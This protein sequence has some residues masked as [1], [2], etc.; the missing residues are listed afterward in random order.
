MKGIHLLAL[1]GPAY[2]IISKEG[3]GGKSCQFKKL[4]L[5]YIN[6]VK[7]V[8]IISRKKCIFCALHVLVLFRDYK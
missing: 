5:L 8:K 6:M 2:L 1:L 3:G 7:Q 4:Q